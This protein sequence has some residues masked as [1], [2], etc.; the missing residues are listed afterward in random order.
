MCD[1]WVP[2]LYIGE[3]GG[4]LGALVICLRYLIIC[5][6][7]GECGDTKLMG[8]FVKFGLSVSG[9]LRGESIALPGYITGL[10][11]PMVHAA[12][13]TVSCKKVTR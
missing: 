8:N 13:A 5:F 6:A 9:H 3:G 2:T 1:H 11:G 12:N 10:P 4:G 7:I